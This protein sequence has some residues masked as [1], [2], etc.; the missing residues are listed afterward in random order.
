MM[1]VSSSS[2]VVDPGV[3]L[4]Y[5]YHHTMTFLIQPTRNADNMAKNIRKSITLQTPP[6]FD[7]VNRTV[8]FMQGPTSMYL[9]NRRLCHLGGATNLIGIKRKNNKTG[10]K[11]IFFFFVTNMK[12]GVV[13]TASV[14]RDNRILT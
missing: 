8:K 5:Q 2:F 6:G 7:Y 11:E 12:I 1:I 3:K 4:I 9:K 10:K 14:R 13:W